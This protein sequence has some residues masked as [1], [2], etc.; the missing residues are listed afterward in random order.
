MCVGRAQIHEEVCQDELGCVMSPLLPNDSL[1]LFLKRLCLWQGLQG[2]SAGSLSWL[3]SVFPSGH[4]CSSSGA[5]WSH[6]IMA[7]LLCSQKHLP[8]GMAL[9]EVWVTLWFGMCL[10]VP[11]WPGTAPGSSSGSTGSQHHQDSW[12]TL[13]PA[14]V[15]Q[16]ELTCL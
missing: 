5:I 3:F 2:E 16:V 7:A 15:L 1:M 4:S 9:G 6:S 14:A 8:Y 11:W 10:A 13:V 12:W